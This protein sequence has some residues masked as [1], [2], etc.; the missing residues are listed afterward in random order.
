M[1]AK[2]KA[3]KPNH[4]IRSK[5]STHLVIKSV[6]F[7]KTVVQFSFLSSVLSFLLTYFDFSENDN[8]FERNEDCGTVFL[9]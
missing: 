8:T 2:A 1:Q 5:T 9:E 3:I 6:H 7:K 4:M